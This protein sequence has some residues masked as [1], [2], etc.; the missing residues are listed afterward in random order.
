MEKILSI[1]LVTIFLIGINALAYGGDN[2]KTTGE[3]ITH[4]MNEHIVFDAQETEPSANLGKGSVSYSRP[5]EF[6]YQFDVKYVRVEPAEHV[7][8]FAGQVTYTSNG[9]DLGRWMSFVVCDEVSEKCQTDMHGSH[10]I[11]DGQPVEDQEAIA[12]E[13]VKNGLPDP[14]KSAIAIEGNLTVH[15]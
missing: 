9:E 14:Y 5:A 10:W 11:P 4:Y 12:L 3:I 8:W 1:T 15:P 13:W 7:A 6:V 2:E